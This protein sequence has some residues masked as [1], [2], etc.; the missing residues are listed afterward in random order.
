MKRL[1]SVLVTLSL[2][3]PHSGAAKEK[4]KPSS[5][6][7]VVRAVPAGMRVAVK[8]SSSKTVKGVVESVTADSSALQRKGVIKSFPA[9][10]VRQFRVRKPYNERSLGWAVT[11]TAGALMGIFISSASGGSLD[12]GELEVRLLISAGVT[13]AAG[14]IG[15]RTNRMR[16]ISDSDSRLDKRPRATGIGP[17]KAFPERDRSSRLARLPQG[18]RDRAGQLVPAEIQEIEVRQAYQG[19]RNWPG[20]GVLREP[21]HFQAVQAAQ[22][23][24]DR[25][26]Q[27]VRV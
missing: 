14:A 21:Q 24:G 8:L 25:P 9:A 4:P 2:L 11:G 23:G 22:V 6:W 15:F 5:D 16:T 1:G 13:A 10:N 20:E 17:V 27:L 3:V 19:G 26:G 18:G 7:S 12:E